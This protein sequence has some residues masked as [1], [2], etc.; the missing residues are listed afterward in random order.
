M[1]HNRILNWDATLWRQSGTIAAATS[2]DMHSLEACSEAHHCL[3][4]VI[5]IR[6]EATQYHRKGHRDHDLHNSQQVARIRH[7][8]QRGFEQRRQPP[9][10]AARGLTTD[11][12]GGLRATG[13]SE[14][15]QR[16]RCFAVHTGQWASVCMLGEDRT[17]QA[18]SLPPVTHE[19]PFHKSFV[20]KFSC[21]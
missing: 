2:Q 13:S 20:P 10:Q 18:A 3:L 14:V 21:V 9:Q 15:P 11:R 1:H 19:I 17:T 12:A 7:P 8:Q 4:L 5:A 6:R 16:R